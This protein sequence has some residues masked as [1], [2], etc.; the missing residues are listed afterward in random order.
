MDDSL[1]FVYSYIIYC[2]YT[3][4]YLQARLI[5]VCTDVSC[6]NKEG[7]WAGVSVICYM[8]YAV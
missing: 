5:D 4:S 8:L 6:T 7:E 1:I 3:V 2:H